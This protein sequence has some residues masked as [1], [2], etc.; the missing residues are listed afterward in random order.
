[1]VNK[2]Y[3]VLVHEMLL[4]DRTR[5]SQY[6]ILLEKACETFLYS[7]VNNLPYERLKCCLGK[8]ADTM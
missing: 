7:F 4:T 2:I 3:F 5:E 1:M 8:T 6:W